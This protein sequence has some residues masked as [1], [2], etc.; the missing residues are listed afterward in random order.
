[1]PLLASLVVAACC[2]LPHSS[3]H[4]AESTDSKSSAPELKADW[5]TQ[6][7]PLVQKFCVDCHNQDLAEAELDLTPFADPKHATEHG[8]TWNRVLA[9]VRFGAMP[10]EDA[11]LPSD[12]ERKLLTQSIDQTLYS[13][14]CDLRPKAGRV[15]AR[16][17]NRVEYRHSIRDLFGID[18]NVND[19]FPTDD[20]GGGFDNNADVLSMPPMLLEK[21]IDAAE[22]IAS[23]VILDPTKLNRTEQERS[24]DGIGIVGESKTESF[25]G[26]ILRGDAFAWVEFDLA[27]LGFTA[28]ESKAV[29]GITKKG[30]SL[31]GLRSQWQAGVRR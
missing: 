15:T 24:G 17:L 14:T 4:A 3:T 30:L 10:P 11:A 28:C 2:N 23:R 20:V 13:A 31:R 9:M 7:W 22:Q 16:R 1:M 12:E 6:G 29:R 18:Y 26:R 25:Y 27:A 8:V 19:S 21:Y 5:Q